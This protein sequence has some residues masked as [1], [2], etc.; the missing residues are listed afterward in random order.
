[1]L[2][3]QLLLKKCDMHVHAH[4]MHMLQG[5]PCIP[6]PLSPHPTYP[7]ALP[8]QLLRSTHALQVAGSILRMEGLRRFECP[9]VMEGGSIHVD[10]E[11]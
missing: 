6:P 1:M 9:I 11:G 5:A 4:D 7:Y 10:G 2:L 3:V 8:C